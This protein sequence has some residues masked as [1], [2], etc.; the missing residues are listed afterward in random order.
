MFTQEYL[1]ELLKRNVCSVTFVKLDGTERTM[2]CTLADAYL[3]EEYRG[4]GT[5]LTEG[6]SS[7]SVWETS[8]NSWKAFRIDTV[9]KVTV[10]NS[11]VDTNSGI[12]Q[13]LKS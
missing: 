6:G 5:I 4:R 8:S 7:L 1:Y 9:K 3:P 13:L 10:E 11:S 12:P 2:E